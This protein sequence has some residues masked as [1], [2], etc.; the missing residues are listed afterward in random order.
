M[1]ITAMALVSALA[2]AEKAFKCLFR[3]SCP[4]AIFEKLCSGDEA[5]VKPCH[6]VLLRRLSP[7]LSLSSWDRYQAIHHCWQPQ[8]RTF[9]LKL[10][11]GW[12]GLEVLTNCC[13]TCLIFLTL[14]PWPLISHPL[15][16]SSSSMFGRLC[17]ANWS[18]GLRGLGGR[19]RNHTSYQTEPTLIQLTRNSQ[20][21]LGTL[22]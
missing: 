13:P 21:S 8:L 10:S 3:H 20:M 19:Q 2:R 16:L 11:K 18:V 6:G 4:T 17:D 12:L 14:S 22:G 7:D 1:V 5:V 9:I 15:S